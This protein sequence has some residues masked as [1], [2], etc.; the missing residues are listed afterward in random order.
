LIF[1]IVF[2]HRMNPSVV[3]Y[4]L[5]HAHENEKICS[6]CCDDENPITKKTAL[7]LN[8][9]HI[10]HISCGVKAL[11]EI[12]MKCSL[13]RNMQDFSLGKNGVYFPI[14]EYFID[15]NIYKRLE[16]F[17]D[18]NDSTNNDYMV[19]H[20]ILTEN[21]TMLEH[22]HNLSMYNIN[23]FNFIM[24]NRK[25]KVLEYYA[26]SSA[27]QD[28]INIILWHAIKKTDLYAIMYLVYEFKAD[29]Y[30]INDGLSMLCYA[31]KSNSF[32]IVSYFIHDL[33]IDVH[34]YDNIAIITAVTE[35]NDDIVRL[36]LEN[37][38]DPNHPNNSDIKLELERE[39]NDVRAL[40]V[41]NAI[42]KLGSDVY[43]KIII[44]TCV[45]KFSMIELFEFFKEKIDRVTQIMS[46]DEPD[47]ES[48]EIIEIVRH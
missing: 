7:V 10:F 43:S 19:K 42:K 9:C 11:I 23:I 29:I 36:C 39:L 44:N 6:I 31:V 45:C 33:G 5:E 34:A 25:Y 26:K 15:N 20:A 16:N 12:D 46:T 35:S 13:C 28:E 41:Q 3:N 48:I 47:E 1:L 40:I 2:I 17:I 8:C 4:I 30:N 21:I 22:L 37:L 24:E 14:I 38:A 32:E 27:N 18:I